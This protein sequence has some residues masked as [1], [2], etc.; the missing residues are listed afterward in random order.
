[1]YNSNE[2]TKKTK[3]ILHGLSALLPVLIMGIAFIR[4]G[5]YP[6]GNRQILVFDA[7]HQYHPF[8]SV[9]WHNIRN[10]NS[11]QWS[12]V[13]G[14]G[15]DYISHIA[16]YLASPFNLIA[17]LFPHSILREVMTVS[18]L[19]R[20]GLAGMFMSLYLRLTIKKYDMLLPFFSCM[21]ALCAFALGYY[22]NVMWFD[23]FALLPLVIL[24][25]NS[26]VNEGK[27]KLYVLSLAMAVLFNFYIG[28]FVCIFVFIMFFIKSYAAKL[29]RKQLINRFIVIAGGSVI[30]VG[31]TAILTIPVYFGLQNAY[32]AT[33]SLPGFSLHR[34]FV[35]VLGNLIAFTPPTAIDGMPNLYSGM[36]AIMLV[37]VFLMSKSIPIREKVAYIAVA[38]FIILSVNV[39]VLDFIW[40]GFRVTNMLPF[41]FS[42]L[43]SFVLV[44]MAYRAYAQMQEVKTRD[45]V[46]M[47]LSAAFFIWMANM[48]PQGAGYVLRAT[49]LSIIYVLIFILATH[50]MGKHGKRT[51]KIGL[52]VIIFIEMS[53]MAYIGVNTVGNTDRPSHPTHYAQIQQL[54]GYR[55]P[56]E[57]DFFRT[58]LNVRWSHNASSLYGYNGISLFSTLADVGT[59]RFLEGIGLSGW[60]RGN[61]FYYVETSPLTNAFLAMRYIIVRHGSPA[62]DGVF[63]DRVAMVDDSILLRNNRYLPFGFMVN[64]AVAY[65]VGNRA[66]PMVSQNELFRRTTGLDHDLFTAVDW[67]RG[68]AENYTINRTGMGEFSFNQTN[69]QVTTGTVRF[70]HIMPHDGL[71]YVYAQVSGANYARVVSDGR[72]PRSHSILRPH[73][74]FAGSFNAGEVVVIEADTNVAHGT[75]SIHVGYFQ[76]ELFE[77]GFEILAASPLVLSEFSDTRIVGNVTVTEPGLLYTSLPHAGNW[78]VFVNGTREEI[79]TI[80]GAMAAVRLGVGTHVVEFRHRNNGFVAGSIISLLSIVAFIAL[81]ILE[82]KGKIKWTQ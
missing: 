58:E 39:N 72:V 36:L 62:D 66:N 79:V 21:Y 43:F 16:Y 6:F 49:V 41:R 2:I 32:S 11:W 18:L 28:F 13:A 12:W 47:G 67:D 50:Y 70:H 69:N 29:S 68:S 40:N 59:N 81:A 15:H 78:R 37:P 7:W 25:V 52:G 63:W 17:V 27:Y 64:E 75:A 65:Y 10:G 31:I 33:G 35:D 42:F 57:V 76:Q 44:A 73:I 80:D 61:R 5:I 30:A 56:L 26:L 46:A 45:I 22:W 20:L 4:Y 3:I 54:L 19:I 48:G 51:L 55:Q 74:F 9:F 53:M 82:R 14:A 23:T 34:S 24:G 1:M 38:I 77:Q 8:T 71:L 60:D